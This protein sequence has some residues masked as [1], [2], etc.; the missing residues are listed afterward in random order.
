MTQGMDI[1]RF[2]TSISVGE[3]KT[4]LLRERQVRSHLDAARCG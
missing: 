4:A 2:E 1:P 3:F